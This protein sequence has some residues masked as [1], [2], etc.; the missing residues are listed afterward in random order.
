MKSDIDVQQTSSL[1]LIRTITDLFRA[2][3]H[4]DSWL[5]DYI[6]LFRPKIFYDVPTRECVGPRD[7]RSWLQDL[8]CPEVTE[9]R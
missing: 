7:I 1:D 3:F 8:M 5:Q 2:Y 4:S 6:D 9:L